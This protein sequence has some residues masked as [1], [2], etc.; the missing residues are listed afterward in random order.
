MFALSGC[1]ALII[2]GE[3]EGRRQARRERAQR[4]MFQCC[5]DEASPEVML[6]RDFTGM[7]LVM[8]ANGALVHWPDG[9]PGRDGLALQ[10][11]APA[12]GRG[13]REGAEVLSG[14]RLSPRLGDPVHRVRGRRRVGTGLLPR[15]PVLLRLLTVS[16]R[17]G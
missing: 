6:A 17:A 3:A 14:L 12:P 4:F 10:S 8:E 5:F 11:A 1:A 7:V 15:L 16:Q 2:R 13:P 9:R